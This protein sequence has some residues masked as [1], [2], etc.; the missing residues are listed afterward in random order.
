MTLDELRESWA[1]NCSIDVEDMTT[2]ASRSPNL[3]A[4]Y[5]D[6]LIQYKLKLIKIQTDMIQ[7]RARRVRYYRGEMTREEL[8]ELDWPQWQ[9]KTLKQEVDGLIDAEPDYIKL[10]TREVYTKTVI[11]YLESVMSEIKSRQFHCRNLIDW[12]K[13]RAGN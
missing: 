5:L 6:E 7:Y 11:Y 8:L 13:H 9:Y 3:H 12:A 2:A 10:V 4:L 1:K